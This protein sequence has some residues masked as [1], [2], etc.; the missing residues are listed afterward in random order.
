MCLFFFYPNIELGQFNL[1]RPASASVNY[2][3]LMQPEGRLQQNF[4]FLSAGGKGFVCCNAKQ[5]YTHT[6][7]KTGDG[8]V[9]TGA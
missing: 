6:A 4:M 3:T 5:I 2:V 9:R 8:H 1:Q 7:I